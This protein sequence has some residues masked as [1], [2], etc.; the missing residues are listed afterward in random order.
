M[1]V[2]RAWED[3]YHQAMPAQHSAQ[4]FDTKLLTSAEMSLR[5]GAVTG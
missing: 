2:P 4:D 5:R 3:V 1:P